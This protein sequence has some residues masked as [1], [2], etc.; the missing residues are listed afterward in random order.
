VLKAAHLIVWG[1]D[2]LGY[3]NLFCFVLAVISLFYIYIY[4]FLSSHHKKITDFTSDI[5]S[6]V[7]LKQKY[8]HVHSVNVCQY[9]DPSFIHSSYDER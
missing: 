3:T 7:G 9:L 2:S 6:V 1:G 4:I 8:A 5:S